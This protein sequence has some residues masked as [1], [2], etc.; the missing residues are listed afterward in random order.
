LIA[1]PRPLRASNDHLF[2]LPAR[3]EPMIILVVSI[4]TPIDTHLLTGRRC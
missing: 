4:A 2:D 1:L 3:H